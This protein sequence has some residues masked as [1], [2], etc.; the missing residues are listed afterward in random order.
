MKK[1]KKYARKKWFPTVIL[2][3][4]VCALVYIIY[5]ST[6]ASA[7]GES[8]GTATGT[9]VGRGIGTVEGLTVGQSEGKKAGKKDGIAAKDT[10][11]VIQEKIHE[12]DKLEVMD[13]TVKLKVICTVG[14]DGTKT[15]QDSTGKVFDAD[16]KEIAGSSGTDNGTR[17]EATS[18]KNTK[19]KAITV[20]DGSIIFTVDMGQA[21]VLRDDENLTIRLPQPENDFS[22]Q[23][24][25]RKTIK[26]YQDPNFFKD[27]DAETGID[28][29]L[30]SMANIQESGAEELA[31]YES[32]VEQARESAKKEVTALAKSITTYKGSITVEF[33]D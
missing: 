12:L 32:L 22:I 5:L 11:V 15:Y 25:T 31:N 4:A 16:G 33:E 21:T 6:M 14:A 29:Q 30:N 27:G 8:V 13:A 10:T 1:V 17:Q 9:V 24:D 2:G 3:V 28:V 26:E 19:Y 18:G 7:I 23:Y 20:M